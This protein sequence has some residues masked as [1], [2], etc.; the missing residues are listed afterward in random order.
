MNKSIK[1]YIQVIIVGLFLFAFAF[2]AW[3]FP[4]SKYSER[5][6]R[7]N[8]ADFP[9]LSFETLMKGDKDGGFMK[10][11]QKYSNERFPLRDSFMSIKAASD[12]YFFRRLESNGY[13]ITDGYMGQKLYPMNK[14][15]FDSALN[16]FQSV[17]DDPNL[18]KDKNTKVYIAVIPDKNAFLAEKIGMLAIDYDEAL[19]YVKNNAGFAEYIDIS[20]MLSIEDYYKTD[21]HWRQEKITDIAAYLAEKMGTELVEDYKVIE[22]DP[23]YGGTFYDKTVNVDKEPIFYLTN[24]VLAGCKVTCFDKLGRPYE[25]TLY[26]I[27]NKAEMKDYYEVFLEGFNQSVVIIENPNAKTDKELVVF[28][29]SF[30]SSMVPLLASGYKTVTVLDIRYITP[31]NVANFIKM[32]LIPS[33]DNKD[34]LFLYSTIV[35]N[36]SAQMLP[37]T[38]SE[39]AEQK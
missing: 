26:N 28:R 34:V 13:Y 39:N 18:V 21:T 7:D 36:D 6:R 32:N 9:E 33:F 3:F 1:D 24:D 29:D 38:Y 22:F 19:A 4:G 35:L 8:L 20:G 15:S 37:S 14:N 30:G 31:D 16:V 12:H 25:T 23:S 10:D 2:A 11:F 5:E 17:C 27:D